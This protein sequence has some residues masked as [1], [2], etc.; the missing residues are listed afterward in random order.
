[1]DALR[2]RFP[3]LVG[4]PSADICYATQNRQDAVKKICDQASVVLVVGSV[5]SSN[6]NRLVEVA[7]SC[8]AEAHLIDD[9]GDLDPIWLEG[10]ETV[11]L[12]AGASSPELLV[13]RVVDRLAE[14]GFGECEEV[15]LTR[16]DVYFRLPAELR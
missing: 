14:F 5:T 4:P 8:G 1:V 15:E 11:G 7:K 6:A 16:E 13:N 2:K 10:H 3:E 12:T 9:A